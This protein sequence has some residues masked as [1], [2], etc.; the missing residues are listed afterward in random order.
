MGT[1]QKGCGELLVCYCSYMECKKNNLERMYIISPI[2]GGA[3]DD[4]KVFN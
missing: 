4:I 2:F 3:E 1:V